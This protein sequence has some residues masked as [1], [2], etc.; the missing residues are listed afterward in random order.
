MLLS[1]P[2]LTIIIDKQS[3]PLSINGNLIIAKYY[4]LAL[5]PRPFEGPGYEANVCQD[6]YRGQRSLPR[7]CHLRNY[8]R[9]L[10][11]M[12][13]ITVASSPGSLVLIKCGGG[14]GSLSPCHHESLGTR[15]STIVKPVCCT[16]SDHLWTGR[17][18]TLYRGQNQ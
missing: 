9:W 15:L 4:T 12:L 3:K 6:Q 1:P 2:L 5:I 11:P 10:R 18:G 13:S 16:C 14:L 7:G 8:Y 17:C